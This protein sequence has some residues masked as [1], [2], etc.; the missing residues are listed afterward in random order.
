MEIKEISIEKLTPYENN[1]RNNDGAVHAVAKSIKQFGFKVPI[2]IDTDNTIVCGHTRLKAAKL[3][4]LEKV[5]C[6]IADDLTEEQIKAFRLVDNKVGEFATWEF[7]ELEKE[8]KELDEMD[9]DFEMSDFGFEL[10][11]VG[12]GY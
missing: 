5:P 9:L 3:L 12:G 1:P 2:V 8:L 11:E 7:A 4:G 10:P 6:I